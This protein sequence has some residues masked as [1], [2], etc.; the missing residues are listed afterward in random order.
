MKIDIRTT[1]DDRARTHAAFLNGAL[2][3]CCVMAD[4]EAGIAITHAV[5]PDGVLLYERAGEPRQ[6][7]HRG[8]I[9]IRKL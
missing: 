1:W 3:P 5:G 8:H 4:E 7:E 6:I 9:E 2:L